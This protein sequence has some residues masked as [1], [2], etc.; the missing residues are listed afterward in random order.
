MKIYALISF[1]CYIFRSSLLDS[2]IDK[3][4]MGSVLGRQ[5]PGGPYVGP[6]NL[7]I[8]VEGMMTDV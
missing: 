2:E 8:W 4:N 7:A 5:D 6:M 1:L 3:A